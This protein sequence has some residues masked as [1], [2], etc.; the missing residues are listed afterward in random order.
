MSISSLFYSY[1]CFIHIR[2]EP[3]TI[4]TKYLVYKGCKKNVHRLWKMNGSDSKGKSTSGHNNKYGKSTNSLFGSSLSGRD[5]DKIKKNIE[6]ARELIKEAPC[7]VV[8]LNP[9]TMAQSD[10]NRLIQDLEELKKLIQ[11]PRL[12]R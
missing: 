9:G 5:D 2:E 11:I 4:K 12:I 1:F 3:L 8:A 7:F 10:I 6:S